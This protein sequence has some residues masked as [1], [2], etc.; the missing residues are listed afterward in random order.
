MAEYDFLRYLVDLSRANDKQPFALFMDNLSVH[1]TNAAKLMYER[2][3]ITPLFNI[4]YQPDLN[5]IEACFSQ[6]KRHFSSRRLHCLANNLE[7]DRE[8]AIRE[9]FGQI[10]VQHVKNNVNRSVKALS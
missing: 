8:G 1:K 5:P 4:P 9:A 2:L 7:F 3:Q 10:Q 6:V